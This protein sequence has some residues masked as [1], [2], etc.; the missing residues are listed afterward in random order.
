[1]VALPEDSAEFYP[2][3]YFVGFDGSTCA[4]DRYLALA[5]RNADGTVH[6]TTVDAFAGPDGEELYASHE[7]RLRGWDAL[8]LR[9]WAEGRRLAAEFDRLEDYWAPWI[10]DLPC[11]GLFDWMGWRPW[12]FMRHMTWAPNPIFPLQQ[13]PR[14]FGL[15][16]GGPWIENP[17]WHHMPA[18]PWR[19]PPDPITDDS[20][21]TLRLWPNE[22]EEA[23]AARREALSRYWGDT[24]IE[25]RQI[26][27]CAKA[28]GKTFEQV[29]A[30]YADLEKAITNPDAVRDAGDGEADYWAWTQDNGL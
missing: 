22:D 14:T 6:V 20:R 25:S 10:A 7:W 26:A 4:G 16:S 29:K 19:I 15:S 17:M 13:H 1:M 8:T 24:S 21:W 5:H 28:T 3:E 11:A 27:E 9:I 23:V 12:E 30:E 2:D 18:A